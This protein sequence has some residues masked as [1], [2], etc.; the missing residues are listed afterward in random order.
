M[1]KRFNTTAICLPDRH[2][3]VDLTSRIAEIRV[4]IEDEKYFVINRA[5][6]YGKT[7]LLR[8]LGNALAGDYAVVSLDF[9]N[10]GNG[11]FATEGMFV[12]AFIRILTAAHKFR[13]LSIPQDAFEQMQELANRPSQDVHLDEL[14]MAFAEWC[15]NSEKP[16]VLMIDEVDS[17]TNN[18]VFLDFLAQLRANYID[19]DIV[20]TFQSVILAGVTDIRNLKRKIR[21]DEDSR[22]NS[23]WNI[24]AD[25]RVRMSFAAEEIAGMISAYE[26]D[27]QTGMDVDAVAE[28]IYEF[29][30]G[31]P[32]LVSRLCQIIDEQM[33]L[34]G[35]SLQEAWSRDGVH[36]A[37][38][39]ILKET[40]T[41]FQSLSGKLF[42]IPAIR[43]LIYGVLMKGE[44][45]PYNPDNDSISQA[46]M[47]GF[48]TEDGSQLVIANRIFE[49]RLYNMFL[50]EEDTKQNPFFETGMRDQNIFVQDGHLDMRKVLE[51]FVTT[52]T[53]I[54]GTDTTEFHEKDGRELFLLYLRPI[55]NGTGNY[56]IEAQTRTMT[57]TDVIVD[58]SGEQFVVELKIW[59]GKEY[60]ERGE[61][62]LLEYLEYFHLQN[63]YMLSFNFNQKKEVGV[64]DR[65]INGHGLIEAVV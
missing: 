11:A 40:N 52:Y 16:V 9:Q 65:E 49:T 55:I 38:S 25:F 10:I 4:M 2:Y 17:A 19:R 59:R 30:S 50:S 18:Q 42:N 28:E 12:Q 37:V 36:E 1:Q 64:F 45:I 34:D 23:P 33:L 46:Y 41:L 31:Y 56:Y 44:R 54:F 21:P 8:A 63:G 27:H 32:F 62:Q 14:F 51:H 24:A 22:V 39:R 20:P 57:R 29:T 6:Q 35:V 7:T 13:K 3:M 58:Y 26:A 47:Y 43:E 5:R 48:L 53:D 60:H 15:S 61:K